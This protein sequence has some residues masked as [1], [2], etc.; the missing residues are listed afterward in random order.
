VKQSTHKNVLVRLDIPEVWSALVLIGY[1]IEAEYAEL[2]ETTSVPAL[3]R[4]VVR[5]A[6]F[7]LREPAA[8]DGPQPQ[9]PTKPKWRFW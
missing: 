3:Y 7:W 9:P 2:P 5:S 6:E 1:T 4:D 8:P